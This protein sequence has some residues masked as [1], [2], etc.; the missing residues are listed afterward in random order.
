MGFNSAFKGSMFNNFFFENPAVYEKVYKNIVE[1]ERLHMTT[2]RIRFYASY[3]RLQTHTHNVILIVFP[4]RQWPHLRASISCCTYTAC[5]LYVN[6]LVKFEYPIVKMVF[7]LV[8]NIISYSFVDILQWNVML[9]SYQ[10][11]FFFRI[12][13][14]LSTVFISS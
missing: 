13:Y 6:V 3:L 4:L 14:S 8:V 12:D 7:I 5:M 11:G 1:P 2:Q 10:T 9:V